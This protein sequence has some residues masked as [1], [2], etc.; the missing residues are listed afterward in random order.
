MSN[1]PPQDLTQLLEDCSQGDQGAMEKLL[2][3]VYEELRR[4]ASAYLKQ[5]RVGHTLQPTAL[6]HEAYLK[7]V[8]QRSVQW[9][10]R[11]HFFAIAAQAMRRILVNHAI[12]RGRLKRGGDRARVSL[13]EPIAVIDE[14]GIDLVALDESLKR[15]SDMDER[16]SRLVE[17]RFFGGLSAEQTAEVLGVSLA[18]VKREWSLAKAWLR[19]DIEK[20]D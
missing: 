20:G 11:A 14:Q 19:R 13:D 2:P 1:S 6:V 7:L 3:L 9:Q 12:S 18:T 16:K 15:L 4:L 17:L 5:E 8:D 10:N